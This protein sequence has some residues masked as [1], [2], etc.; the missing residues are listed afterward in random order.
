MGDLKATGRGAF[1]Q[2]MIENGGKFKPGKGPMGPP[3]GM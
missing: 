1:M 2:E 3:P